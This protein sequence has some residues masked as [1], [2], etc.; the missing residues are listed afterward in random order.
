MSAARFRPNIIVTLDDD[1]P[2]FVENAWVGLQIAIGPEVVLQ[3]TGACPRC[4]M[5]TLEQPGHT[6][7]PGI[8]RALAAKNDAHAG[9]CAEVVRGGRLHEGDVVSLVREPAL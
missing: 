2:G 6:A 3:V 7:D 4:V 9:V 5:T 1:E 8:L